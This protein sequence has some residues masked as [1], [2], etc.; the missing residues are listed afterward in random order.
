MSVPARAGPEQRNVLCEMQEVSYQLPVAFFHDEPIGGGQVTSGSRVLIVDDDELIL[1]SLQDRLARDGHEIL[2]ASTGREAF[3]AL[4]E[5]VD[6]VVLD[7]RLPDVEGLEILRRVREE[8]ATMP[9]VLITGH[10]TVEHAVEAM[11]AGAYHYAAK[12][13]DPDSIAMTV[14]R[15]LELTSLRQQLRYLRGQ[16]Q[17]VSIIGECTAMLQVKELIARVAL[18]PASTVLLTGESGTGKD[19]CARALHATSDR[20][21]EA[22]VAI[23]CAAIPAA[24]LESELFGHER[25][26]FTDAKSRRDGLFQQADRGTLFLDEIGEMAPELQAKLLRF[27]EDKT[28]RRVGGSVEMSADVRVIAATNVDL[29]E[30]VAAGRF[31]EDLYYR[32][33]VVTVRLPPL[34]ERAADIDLLAAHLVDT[35]NRKFRKHITAISEDAKRVLRA[36]PWPGNVR[37]LRN[38][39]ERAVLLARRQILDVEDFAVLGETAIDPAVVRLP[40]GGVDIRE[41]ERSLIEQALQRTGGNQTRAAALLHMNRDQIRYRMRQYGLLKPT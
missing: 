34:R 23:S 17:A 2:T 21:D 14:A 30:A 4:A 10:S 3:R 8:D 39:I 11:T 27:L 36:H 28:F 22:F 37:E 13:V 38:A 24:L 5:G 15:A 16:N 20:A 1:A 35:Y 9:V 19:L 6:V 12:P 33:A 31:R 18:S 41:V 29:R 32:L 7:N 40:A 25:G 26:A